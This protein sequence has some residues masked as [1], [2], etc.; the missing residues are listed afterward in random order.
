[1]RTRFFLRRVNAK[2]LGPEDRLNNRFDF[3][4]LLPM[5]AR[6]MRFR[7]AR[8]GLDARR[9][10]GRSLGKHTLSFGREPRQKRRD[11]TIVIAR[12]EINN[13]GVDRGNLGGRG[14]EEFGIENA[15]ILHRRKR[16]WLGHGARM[17]RVKVGDRSGLC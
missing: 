6:H 8:G 13:V 11:T 15:E 1:M 9:R 2:V 5:H 10:H 16:G 4:P 12:V 14:E 17:T 3:A 7:G